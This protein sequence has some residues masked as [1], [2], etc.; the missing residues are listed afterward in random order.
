MDFTVI[1][2]FRPEPLSLIISLPLM[3]VAL[4]L[5]V[6]SAR[7]AY[8]VRRDPAEDPF[9]LAGPTQ[10]GVRPTF[11]RLKMLASWMGYFVATVMVIIASSGR[12]P[13]W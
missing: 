1:S 9:P 5:A 6:G 10:D 7:L 4:A 12:V 3:L 11:G 8:L 13:W 2:G